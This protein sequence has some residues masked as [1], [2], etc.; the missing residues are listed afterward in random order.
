MGP[1]NLS[2]VARAVS[3]LPC[4]LLLACGP[5]GNGG[6][7]DPFSEPAADLYGNGARLHEVLGPATWL[8]PANP[9]SVDCSG[10]P[11]DRLTQITGITVTSIDRFDETG[12]GAM[13]NYYVQDTLDPALP[14]S[15]ITVFEPGFSPP[16]LRVVPGD[17]MDIFGVLTEFP[18]PNGSLFDFCR[19]LPE[20]SGSMEYRFEGSSITPLPI[21]IADLADYQSARKWL[22]VLVTLE[23]VT[24]SEAPYKSAVGRYTI[25]METGV[26]IASSNDIPSIS[27]ELMDL[28]ALVPADTPA[29]TTLTRVTGIVTFFFSFHIAP[30]SAEDIVL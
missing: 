12:D 28:E 19:T 9:D 26:P 25:R 22:G 24:F 11:Q 23:N 21:P 30:R 10:A 6:A 20:I 15:G 18:G 1:L 4:L 29:G 5:G 8:D 13:G 17:V 16:D 3:A 7:G 2:I 14:Y 27:N